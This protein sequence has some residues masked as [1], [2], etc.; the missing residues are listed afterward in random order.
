MS[1]PSRIWQLGT[2]RI[3]RAISRQTAQK[4]RH[5]I[6]ESLFWRRQI[7]VAWWLNAI[8]LIAAVIA[9]STMI[10]LIFTLVDA[11]KA[12]VE[13]NRAWIAP[14]TALLGREFRLNDHLAFRIAYD[15][16]GRQPARN[17]N[18]WSGTKIVDAN[19]LMNS[20][21]DPS[22]VQ[23]VFQQNPT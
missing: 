5:D 9:V 3:A 11:R 22:L 14:H 20:L 13:A 18:F 6:E 2:C 8:T 19:S 7:R 15:N 12:T 10:V 23:S 4:Q 21:T 17:E 16:V 1:L